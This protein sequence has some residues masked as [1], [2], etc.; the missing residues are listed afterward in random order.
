MRELDSHVSRGRMYGAS[1]FYL[2]FD[3]QS[4]V[5]VAMT[6]LLVYDIGKQDMP[7]WNDKHASMYVFLL[8]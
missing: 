8:T 5:D 6:Y 1:C 7:N 3:M 4:C 2:E